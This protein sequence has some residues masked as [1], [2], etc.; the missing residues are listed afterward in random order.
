MTCKARRYAERVSRMRHPYPCVHGH[1]DCAATERGP[2]MD[3]LLSTCNCPECEEE[4]KEA[5]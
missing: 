3:E 4:R 1:F 5:T 2:C